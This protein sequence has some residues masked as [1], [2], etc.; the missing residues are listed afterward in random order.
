[1][2]KTL[3]KAEFLDPLKRLRYFFI[4]WN[5]NLYFLNVEKIIELLNIYS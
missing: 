4:Y 5:I 1:M 2:F 3:L